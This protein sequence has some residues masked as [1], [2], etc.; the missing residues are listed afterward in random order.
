MMRLLSLFFLIFSIPSFSQVDVTFKVDMQYQIVSFDGIHLAGSMQGWNSESTPLSDNDGDNIWEVNLT[1]AQNSTHEFKF[2]NGNSWGND[3]NVTGI[4]GTTN[5]NRQLTVLNEDTILLAYVFNSCDY[6]EYGCIDENAL[7]YNELANTDDGSCV[8]LDTT[9]GCTDNLACNF[10]I[11]ATQEDS[12]CVYPFEGFDCDSNCIATNID[13]VGDQNNDGFTSVDT[14]TNLAYITIE[15]YPNIGNAIISI[16]NENF[17]MNY[18]DWGNNAHWYI[19]LELIPNSIY[20]WS[21]E[22]SNLCASTQIYS[23]SFTTD[24]LNIINGNTLELGCGCGEDEPQPG[25]DCDGNCLEDSDFDGICDEFEILGCTDTLATNFESNATDDDGSCK[26]IQIE[27]CMDEESC[28]FNPNATINDNSCIFFTLDELNDTNLCSSSTIEIFINNNYE[29]YLWSTGDTTNSIQIS[30]AGTYYVTVTNEFGC[31]SSDTLNINYTALPYVDIGDVFEL[32]PNSSVE[33]DLNNN[34]SST[35]II[36]FENG[37]T[38]SN[39]IPYNLSNSGIYKL[40]VTDSLGCIGYDVFEVINASLPIANFEYI[41]NN[42]LLSLNNLSLNANNYLWEIINHQNII[43]DTLE[44]TFIEV[45][46]CYNDT[47]ILIA[48]NNCGYDTM[49]S[50]FNPTKLDDIDSEFSVYPNP[51]IDNVN[52]YGFEKFNQFFLL[53]LNGKEILRGNPSKFVNLNNLSSGQYNLI[54]KNENKLYSVKLFK[55]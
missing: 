13:W 46:L 51:F 23:S 44:N 15:S 28:N 35:I 10:N 11:N 8:F 6:T 7:N 41:F 16:N 47:I 49:I 24:C 48:E 19:E 25:Y 40:I 52:V 50:I 1:L 22:I 18:T 34:W 38:I 43:Q 9:Y 32:C 21:V 55:Y 20:N 42:N 54:L 3:E 31:Q 12:S 17:N 5:G 26:Y 36:D 14:S 53:D 30:Q 27:G 37:D 2:I 4:C 33:I 29:N 39:I 45:E